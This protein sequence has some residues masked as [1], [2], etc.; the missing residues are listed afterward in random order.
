MDR[1]V[2]ILA[3]LF[4]ALVTTLN[5]DT[6]VDGLSNQI[7]NIEER[8]DKLLKKQDAEIDKLAKRLEEI[9]KKQRGK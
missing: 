8:L 6:W 5:L 3:V 2:I 1:F 4:A 9:S 7:T